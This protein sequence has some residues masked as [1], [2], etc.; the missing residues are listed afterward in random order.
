VFKKDCIVR[1][2]GEKGNRREKLKAVY[3]TSQSKEEKVWGDHAGWTG[4]SIAMVSELDEIWGSLVETDKIWG[5]K[6][7]K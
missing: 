5:F 6:T 7:P 1:G 2:W 3:N 4:I